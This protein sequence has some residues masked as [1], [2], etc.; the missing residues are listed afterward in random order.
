M[1]QPQLQLPNIANVNAAVN[2]M[3]VEGNNI[4]Q[5]VVQTLQNLQAYNGHQQQLNAELSLCTNYPVG[6]VMQQLNAIQQQQTAMQQQL[7]AIQQQQ[8]GM[9]GQVV[10]IQQTTAKTS[11]E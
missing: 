11:A 6:Q 2:G 9:H 10:V 5:N 1:A 4:V 7:N 8:N 3:A